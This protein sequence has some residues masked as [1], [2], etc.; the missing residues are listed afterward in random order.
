VLAASEG[1]KGRDKAD[2]LRFMRSLERGMV[3][4]QHAWCEFLM[5]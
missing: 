5:R 4:Y 3:H 2:C 1:L